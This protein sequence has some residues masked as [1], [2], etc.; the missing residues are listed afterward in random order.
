MH[1]WGDKDF[2]WQALDNAIHLIWWWSTKVGRFGGQIKEKWGCLRF[3]VFFS[4]GTLHSLCKPGY[5]YSQWPK[6]FYWG[7][8]WPIIRRVIKYSGLL[9]LIHRWQHFIYNFAYQ[10][11]VKRFPHIREE[12]LID[13]D[14]LELIKGTEDI[15]AQW[16]PI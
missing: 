13:A 2:D 12:I 6:W 16:K 7:I 9:W 15:R 4:D 5:Y 3:Y 14:L 8:D 11:A 1:I 10:R